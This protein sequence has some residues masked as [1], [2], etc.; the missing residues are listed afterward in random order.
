MCCW[1]GPWPCCQSHRGAP[2]LA[3]MNYLH[4]WFISAWKAASQEAKCLKPEACVGLCSIS[5]LPSTSPAHISC[6][7]TSK[8]RKPAL[9]ESEGAGT[10][11]WIQGHNLPRVCCGGRHQ[12]GKLP[13]GDASPGMKRCAE[14]SR[15]ASFITFKRA[16]PAVLGV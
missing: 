12:V 3:E 5:C 13:Q 6:F 14:V 8:W 15:L 9:V 7:Q 16:N 4:L 10:D 2:R 11:L 1:G